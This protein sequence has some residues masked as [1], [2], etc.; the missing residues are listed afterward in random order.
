MARGTLDIERYTVAPGSKVNLAKHDP[1]DDGGL[2]KGKKADKLLAGYLHR[3]CDLQERLYAERSRALLVVLQAMDTGGKDGTVKRVFTGVNPT[4]C[5]V[6]SFK[7]PSEEELAHDFLWRIRKA[8]PRYGEIGIFNRSHYE[9]VLIVRVHELVPK[10]VWR[11]RYDRINHFEK[12][13]VDSGIHILKFFL[14]ISKDEQ[15]ER[16]EARLA[17]KAKLW[18]FDVGDL[19]ERKRWDDYMKAYTDA[20]SKCSTE[21]A[22]W[23]V[24]PANRKWFRDIVV[25]ATIVDKLES[26][27]PQPRQPEIDPSSI[28]VD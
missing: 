6:T 8:V 16:L 1:D 13:L 7:Q 20:L 19:A 3:L 9:D 5:R 28:T 17:D 26:L 18:K 24:V 27:D 25:A 23:I 10:E 15:K 2:E 11:S 14:H 22:P 12:D 4:G 21:W